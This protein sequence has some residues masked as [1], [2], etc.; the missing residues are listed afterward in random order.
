[1][2]LKK[3]QCSARIIDEKNPMLRLR[4][5]VEILGASDIREA[6][7]I[8]DKIVRAIEAECRASGIEPELILDNGEVRTYP[9]EKLVE[10]VLNYTN[11]DSSPGA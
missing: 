3:I 9:Q 1:M 2:N 10:R 4:Y 5:T 7:G 11:S 8:H 6:D